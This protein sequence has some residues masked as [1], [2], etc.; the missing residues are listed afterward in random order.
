MSASASFT[1]A[2]SSGR[3]AAFAGLVA[4]TLAGCARDAAEPAPAPAGEINIY[5]ARHYESD[6]LIYDG[7]TQATGVKVNTIEAK[8][9]LLIEKL[10]AEGAASPADVILTV[11]AGNLWRAEQAGLFQPISSPALS[12]AI[13]ADERHPQGLWFGFSKRA[14]IIVYDKAKVTPDQLTDYFDLAKPAWKGKVCARASGNIYNLSLMS[15]MIAHYGGDRARAWAKGVAEN[16]ARE[17]TGGDVDQIK[18]VADGVCELA[19]V[20]HYYWVRMAR[21]SDEAERAAAA[22]TAIFFPD[23]KGFGAHVNV[24]GAGVAAHAPNKDNAIKFLEYLAT[25]QVQ[26]IFARENNEFPT[27][28]DTAFDNPELAALKGFKEDDLPATVLGE[29][30]PQAQK[31]FDEAGWR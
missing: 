31:L 3:I 18:A 11:D 4:L 26:A 9:E 5:S 12:T 14:R 1:A 23:Q 24:A 7:F 10:K 15:M 8:A 19:L 6:K 13:P 16:F 21:S 29:N 28:A 30:Q 20:N 25:P 22:K 17:P 27:V 2:I